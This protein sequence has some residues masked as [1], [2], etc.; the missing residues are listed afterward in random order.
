MSDI[1]SSIRRPYFKKNDY[2]RVIDSNFNEFDRARNANDEIEELLKDYRDLFTQIPPEIHFEIAR[3]S[4]QLLGIDIEAED[5]EEINRLNAI[6]DELE[7]QLEQQDFIDAPE[8]PHFR[9]GTFVN[10]GL[11]YYYMQ[12]GYARPIQGI[13]L[14]KLLFNIVYKIEYTDKNIKDKVSFPL[15]E[16]ILRLPKAKLITLEVG[17]ETSITDISAI[18][19]ESFFLNTYETIN[20]EFSTANQTSYR[21]RNITAPVFSQIKENTLIELEGEYNN[22]N[23]LASKENFD[24]IV[25]FYKTGSIPL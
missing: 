20:S 9:N 14:F 25:K 23:K 18:K 19:I 1:N 24:E 12:R 5:F 4:G 7:A 6:I 21:E 17:K 13:S 22:P 10:G 16:T 2:S 8:H 11:I 15:P 3:L